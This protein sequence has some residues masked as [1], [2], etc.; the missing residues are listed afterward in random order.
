MAFR[1]PLFPFAIAL[2]LES[3]PLWAEEPAGSPSLL[4]G[5]LLPPEE[6]DAA[7]LRQ[8]VQLG[9]DHANEAPGPR[10]GLVVRGRVGQ[11]GADGEEAARMALDDG[12]RGLIAPPGGASSHLALQVAGRTAVPVISLCPDASVVGAGIPW[13]VRVVPATGEEARTLFSGLTART[14]GCVT[15]WGACVPD[16]R[17]GREVAGDL[18]KAAQ[19]SQAQLDKIIE[20][21][22]KLTN[23]ASLVKSLLQAQ[24]GAIL[25]WLD[26]A[27]AGRLAKALREAGFAGTLAGPGRLRSAAFV[28]SAGS[29]AEGVVVPGVVMDKASQAAQGR[30]AAAYRQR[31]GA[32]PDL[33]ATMAYDAATLLVE[34][35]RKAGDQPP[36]RVFPLTPGPVGASGN[37]QFDQN[38]NRLAALNLLMCR[39]GR[40]TPLPQQTA[41]P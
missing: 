24:P 9:V 18:R 39:Q 12:A 32:D 25:L 11:W 41:R 14:E 34:L 30:F 20:V 38:G 10:V 8:G 3:V 36:H 37:L 15:R 29:A 7:S 17:A 33:T 2:I 1:A 28:A 5:L 35:L 13:M 6:V 22:P 31:F 4:I 23:V 27:P 26:P 16:E 19:A 21:S 40:F